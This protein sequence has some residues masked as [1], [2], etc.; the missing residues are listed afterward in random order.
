M[1]HIR[2]GPNAF[3][4]RWPSGS[5]TAFPAHYEGVVKRE[6]VEYAVKH[7][8]GEDMDA[9]ADVKPSDKDA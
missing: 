8:L 3:D 2:V 5:L 1:A 4:Y 9:K 7:K 6:V